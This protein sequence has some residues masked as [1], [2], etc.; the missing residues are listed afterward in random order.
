[1]VIKRLVLVF[2]VCFCGCATLKISDNACD[3]YKK[4]N[5]INYEYNNSSIG[6]WKKLTY[7][8]TRYD[9]IE[10]TISTERPFPAETTYYKIK[11]LDP[12]TY[13]TTYI[14][15]ANNW[16]DS[17]IRNK[18]YPNTWKNSIIKGTD[19]Y[20]IRARNMQRDTIWIQ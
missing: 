11:W 18:A 8:I 16:V 14:T 9:S 7:L 4:G 17:L 13:E 6:H 5:F 1:M 20:Y 15:G 3:R 10:T 12:C 19:K 2:L